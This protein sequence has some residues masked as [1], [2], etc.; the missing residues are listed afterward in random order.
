[1]SLHFPPLTCAQVK[2][3]LKNLCFSP[4]PRKSTSHEQW[5]KEFDGQ[6]YKVTVDC[7]KS[8]FSQ[9]LIGSMAHQAGV[10]KKTFYNALKK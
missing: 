7:P 6:I 10:S 4:L 8:P 5:V 9:I 1:M 2:T 3:I